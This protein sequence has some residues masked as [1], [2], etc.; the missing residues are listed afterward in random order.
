VELTSRSAPESSGLQV[1]ALG[2]SKEGII[3]QPQAAEKCLVPRGCYATIG[4]VVNLEALE[5]LVQVK[6]VEIAGRTPTK[7][8]GGQCVDS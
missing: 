8:R 1:L 4:Q 5:T 7:V 3:F 6:P 2:G